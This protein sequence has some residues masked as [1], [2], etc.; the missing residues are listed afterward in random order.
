MN[1]DKIQLVIQHIEKNYHRLIAPKELED[2]AFYSYRNLQRIFQNIFKE[3]LG[4]FQKR[5]KLE[6]GYKKLIYTHDSITDIAFDVGFESLQAFTKSFKKQFHIPPSDARNHKAQV[7]EVYIAQNIEK[8]KIYYEIVY[9]PILTVFYQ[10]IKTTNYNNSDINALWDNLDA[11]HGKQK[12]IQYYGIIA[13]Q[14]LI[15]VKNHCRYEAAINQ[16]SEGFATKSI[17]GGK[18]AKYM[19]QGAY[20]SIENTYRN[21]YKDWLSQS[22]LEFDNSPIIEH[23]VKHDYNSEK[24]QNFITEIFIPL[25]KE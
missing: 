24:E 21:I 12:D 2:I 16:P 23:Y 25:K 5:L 13:D 10:I 7:F 19:H 11:L 1:F 22:K 9:L 17:F 4:E 14:P 15:T 8:T 20:D 6:N 3:S 18:Y